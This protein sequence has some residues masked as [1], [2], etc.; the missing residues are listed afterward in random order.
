M[1]ATG[2]VA[3]PLH[4]TWLP[5]W[6]TAAVGFTVTEKVLAGPS[7]VKV[8]F[9]KCGVTTMV[10]TTGVVP[11]LTA[12]NARMFPFPFPAR[13]MLVEELVQVYV[14]VPPVFTVVKVIAE[15]V[16]PLQTTWLAGWSTAAVGFTVIVNVFAG[17]SHVTDPF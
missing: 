13:P 16:L 9:S 11:V 6:S 12:G 4:P 3:D 5:G 7:Q 8:P 1:K 10:A 17:P 14:V 2:V 15:T